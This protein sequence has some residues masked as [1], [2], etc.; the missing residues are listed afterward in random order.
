M[1]RVLGARVRISWVT[2]LFEKT[3]EMNGCAILP[4]RKRYCSTHTAEVDT[5]PVFGQGVSSCN[6]KRKSPPQNMFEISTISYGSSM[7][8]SSPVTLFVT[9]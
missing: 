8:A 2:I 6:A 3:N 4:I 1:G 9:R 7:V 5:Q